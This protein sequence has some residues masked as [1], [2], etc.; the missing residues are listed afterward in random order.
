MQ[1]THRTA[2][3]FW[4]AGC[5]LVN[6]GENFHPLDRVDAK[7]AFQIHAKVQHVDR[8]AGFFRDDLQHQSSQ[9]ERGQSGDAWRTCN[10][11]N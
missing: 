4:Q 1:S 3:E 8:I 5:A 9:I 7:I 10:Q 6:S 11:C 2:V